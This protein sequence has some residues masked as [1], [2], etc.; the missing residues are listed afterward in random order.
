MIKEPKLISTF[1]GIFVPFKKLVCMR[2][3]F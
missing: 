1:Y 3:T 2:L